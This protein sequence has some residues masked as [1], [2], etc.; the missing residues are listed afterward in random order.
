MANIAI[1][2]Y[3]NLKCPYCF[4]NEFIEEKKQLIT[5][6][7]L[8]EILNWLGKSEQVS[9]VGIIG[10]EPTIHKNFS[11]I[12]LKTKAFAKEHNSRVCVFSNG[13]LLGDYARLFDPVATVLVNV[14]HPDIVG[15]SNWNQ[16]NMTLKR[17]AAA[18]NHNNISL[19]INLYPDMIDF[20]YIVELANKFRYKKIRCSYV[21]PTCNYKG[22]DKDEYYLNAKTTFLD[23]VTLCDKYNIKVNLDCNNVPECYFTEEELDTLKDKVEGWKNLCNPV[24]DITPDM[25]GTACFGAYDLVDLH[26]FSN[27]QEAETYFLNNKI[28]PKREANNA[29]ACSNCTKFSDNTCQ[30]GCL[31]FSGLKEYNG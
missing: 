6:E 12:M 26:Q 14:N 21:A 13:I 24:V 11:E 30:G 16:I 17:F 23:F 2:N 1:L 27:L 3:C 15:Y 8:D 4:A 5:F 25:H 9:R 18:G 29:G 22:V 20:D 31:A 7:Q 28:I 10:G 19:G